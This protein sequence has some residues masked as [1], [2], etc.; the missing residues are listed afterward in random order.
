M[1]MFINC[2]GLKKQGKKSIRKRKKDELIRVKRL[3]KSINSIKK[4]KQMRDGETPTAKYSGHKLRAGELVLL[5][6]VM[7]TE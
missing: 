3:A 5:N 4:L 1:I 2:S 6:C 7:I